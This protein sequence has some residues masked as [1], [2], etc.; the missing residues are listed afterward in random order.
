M[1][2]IQ[3][4]RAGAGAHPLLLVL[5]GGSIAAGFDILFA[6]GFWAL[7]DVPAQRILQSVAA[8]VLGADAYA[9]GATS[10]VFGL[11]LHT[12]IAVVMALVYFA[13]SRRLRALVR[14]PV[15]FGALYGVALYL[16]MNWIVVPLSAAS[17]A[18]PAGLWLWC[19]L[20]AHIALVG[21]P[22]ALAARLADTSIR[23]RSADLR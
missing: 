7:R 23:R 22:C 9:A 10:A 1:P 4:T 17:M 15:S 6:I 20:A 8:G 18:P 14:W 11:V 21:I 5:A 3:P 2:D 19:G 16:A 13:A 12:A